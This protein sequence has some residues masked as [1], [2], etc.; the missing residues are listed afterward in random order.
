MIPVLGSVL[1]PLARL[2]IS[3]SIFPPNS[4]FIYSIT[5][6][7]ISSEKASPMKFLAI[8]P[9]LRAS[10]VK[11]TVFHQPAVPTLLP[12]TPF[13]NATPIVSAPAPKAKDILLARP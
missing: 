7:F 1:T 9:S 6:S 10:S 13:S 8:N 5:F 11:A 3:R 2:Y 12:S 4:F